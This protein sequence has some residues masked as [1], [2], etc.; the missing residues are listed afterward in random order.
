MNIRSA[1]AKG[2]RL[3]Q[4]VRDLFLKY[5]PDLHPDDIKVTSASVGG[6]DVQFSPAARAAYWDFAIECKNQERVN[7]WESYEQACEHARKCKRTDAIP[8]LF[9]SRNRTEPLA[10]IKAE[11][12]LKLIS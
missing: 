7:I 4:W 2:R 12:L 1:K 6:E 11:D 10:V 8:L 3:A 5:K 9:I